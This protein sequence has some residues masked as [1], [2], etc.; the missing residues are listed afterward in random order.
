MLLEE[1]SEAAETDGIANITL[2][3]IQRGWIHE[4]HD[5]RDSE[6]MDQAYVVSV[7]IDCLYHLISA[8]FT[9]AGRWY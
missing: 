3:E 1:N 5:I 4:Y 8:T 2:L 6:R 7:S 9:P